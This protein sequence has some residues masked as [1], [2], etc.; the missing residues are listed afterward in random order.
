[1]SSDQAD[2]SRLQLDV[3]LRDVVLN[4]LSEV[5]AKHTIGQRADCLLGAIKKRFKIR[6]VSL[7][8]RQGDA[9]QTLRSYGA[10]IDA[11]SAIIH[12][13]TPLGKRLSA[14][15]PLS[16]VDMRA[17]ALGRRPPTPSSMKPS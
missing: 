5:Y 6:T 13:D 3:A 14:G 15:K 4:L 8:E 17:G 7:L 12:L 1:M 10:P 9:L 16:V 11:S 2:L